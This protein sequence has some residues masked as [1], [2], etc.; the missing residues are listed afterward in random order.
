MTHYYYFYDL[1]CNDTST[2]HCAWSLC[3]GIIVP[4]MQSTDGDNDR[5]YTSHTSPLVH[6]G[7]CP[8]VPFG[9]SWYPPKIAYKMLSCA[10]VLTWVLMQ[11]RLPPWSCQQVAINCRWILVEYSWRQVRQRLFAKTTSLEESVLQ[12]LL[13]HFW[14]PLLVFWNF[15]ERG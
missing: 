7:N 8:E 11:T 10:C 14:L 12:P 1:L 9:T 2:N 3:V 6:L 13:L 15:S 4:P 5:T